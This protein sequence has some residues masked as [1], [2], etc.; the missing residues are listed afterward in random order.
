MC[1]RD[2]HGGGPN[3]VR[4]AGGEGRVVIAGEDF[5]GVAEGAVERE[6]GVGAEIGVGGSSTM[7]TVLADA[8]PSGEE[9]PDGAE[10][11]AAGGIFRGIIRDD[12]HAPVGLVRRLGKFADHDVRFFL[13]QQAEP[14]GDGGEDGGLVDF[15][16]VL[17]QGESKTFCFRQ[18]ECVVQKSFLLFKSRSDFL[19]L[20]FFRG[21][22]REI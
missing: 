20:R 7:V 9:G 15:F 18:P 3:L 4:G 17:V 19:A 16:V 21:Q 8:G 1:I 14:H 13:I 11:V 6:H 10:M 12:A 5:G 2:S 22:M